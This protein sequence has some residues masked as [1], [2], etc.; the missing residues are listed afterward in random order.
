M[1]KGAAAR[2]VGLL[3]GAPSMRGGRAPRPAAPSGDEADEASSLLFS[4]AAVQNAAESTL[5]L[6]PGRP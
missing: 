3:I 1:R 4:E 2:T 5:T 6:I